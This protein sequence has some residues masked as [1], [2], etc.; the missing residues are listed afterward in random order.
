MAHVQRQDGHGHDT[1]D[2][3]SGADAY[4]TVEAAED[5][6]NGGRIDWSIECGMHFGKNI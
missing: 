6:T 2:S 3:R 1:V 5:A 4:Q